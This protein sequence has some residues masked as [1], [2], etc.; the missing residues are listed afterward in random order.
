AA[1]HTIAMMF[2]LARQI[3]MA[4]RSTQAG[5]WEKSRFLGV[6]LFGKTLGVI[7]CGN[8]GAIVAGRAL[9]LEMKV[10]AYDPFLSPERARGIGVEKVELNE[11]LARADFITLHTPLNDATRN[12]IDAAAIARMKRGVRIIN[13]ARGGLVAEADLAAAAAALHH[14]RGTARELCRTIDRDRY[15]RRRDRVRRRSR[16]GES[17]AADRDGLGGAV[18]AAAGRGQ[19]C[20]CS[21]ALHKARH[22]RCRNAAL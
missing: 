13:C 19:S 18:V 9:G 17:K 10:I 12:L 5:K 15:P 11:L 21:A 8:I 1:E 7:G 3:P 22:S 6:E 2:A 20:Q 16:T 4:D 14:A